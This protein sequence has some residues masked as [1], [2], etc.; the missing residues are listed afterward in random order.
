MHIK[1]VENVNFYSIKYMLTKRGCD[2]TR[3]GLLLYQHFREG[4]VISRIDGR[5]VRLLLGYIFYVLGMKRKRDLFF[6]TRYRDLEDTVSVNRNLGGWFDV[7]GCLD[8]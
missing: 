7:D 3:H 5:E 6:S 8:S 4:A 1:I 2:V